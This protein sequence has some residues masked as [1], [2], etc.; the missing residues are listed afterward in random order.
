MTTTQQT[1][2]VAAVAASVEA[3]VE[4]AHDN[5]TALRRS[6]SRVPAMVVA[7][8]LLA[9]SLPAIAVPWL[10]GAWSIGLGCAV[11]VAW[12]LLVTAFGGYGGPVTDA[13]DRP[14]SRAVW[15]AACGLA[16]TLWSVAAVVPGLFGGV[17]STARAVLALAVLA[18][19]NTLVL[20]RAAS[21][22]PDA[23]APVDATAPGRVA[24]DAVDR[25]GAVVLL[26]ALAPLI[27][28]LSVLVRLDSPGSAF[29][30]Q[31]RVGRDGRTFTMLKLRTMHDG[32]EGGVDLLASANECDPSSLL[33]KIRRDPRLT[34]IGAVLRRYSL[35]E[36]PQLVNVLRGEMSLV[37]PRPALPSEARAYTEDQ[38][39]RL[40]VKP[41]MTGLWQVSGRSDLSW[42]ESVRLDL[43]Y[44]DTWSWWM[45]LGIAVRTLGAVVTHRGAY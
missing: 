6:L 11:P 27:A 12:L 34:P 5:A 16:M 36:L 9:V 15:P 45:D 29:F 43:T 4:V 13:Q 23:P 26:I 10:L 33:F 18:P 19:L 20:R 38:Q 3:S 7:I 17:G 32:A 37:G 42:E 30:R 21:L 28:A 35:D 14:R 24:K 1:L 39:R 22:E 8:D 44:V 2:P 41:G 40:T 25:L 31:T